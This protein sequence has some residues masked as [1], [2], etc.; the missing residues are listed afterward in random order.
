MS[1]DARAAGGDTQN[2]AAPPDASQAARPPRRKAGERTGP[3]LVGDNYD[4]LEG[5]H[6]TSHHF[7]LI[8]PGALQGV[9]FCF[10]QKYVPK[11][12][13]TVENTVF[14]MRCS[15]RSCPGRAQIRHGRMKLDTSTNHLCLLENPDDPVAVMDARRARAEMKKRAR[16]SCDSYKVMCCKNVGKSNRR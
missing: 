3:P 11:K 7:F 10:D 4:S 13:P 6:R 8:T 15:K 1:D 16:E 12:N 5:V 2:S 9:T 14:Y